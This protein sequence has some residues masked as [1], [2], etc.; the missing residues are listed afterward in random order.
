VTRCDPCRTR[1]GAPLAPSGQACCG[2]RRLRTCPADPPR[3]EE[4][5]LATPFLL[6]LLSAILLTTAIIDAGAYLAAAARAQGAADAAALAATAA[7]VVQPAPAH[8]VARSVAGRN[9]ARVED[10]TCHAGRPL[11]EVTVS[12]PVGGLVV[13]RTFG[14]ARVTA[15]AEAQLVHGPDAGRPPERG[16]T[17]GPIGEAP[18]QPW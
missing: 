7:D 5:S 14:A 6:L 3:A 15:S 16:P 12:V 18:A 1:T 17:P 8:I 10:C 11:V 4:G 2:A 13:A 9:G